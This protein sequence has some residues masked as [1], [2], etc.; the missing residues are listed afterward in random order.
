MYNG[1]V[2]Q[3]NNAKSL[4]VNITTWRLIEASLKMKWGGV[5]RVQCSDTVVAM[6]TDLAQWCHWPRL[7]SK[8]TSIHDNVLCTCLSAVSSHCSTM[9]WPS[10]RRLRHPPRP[11]IWSCVLVDFCRSF[12][13]GGSAGGRGREMKSLCHNVNSCAYFSSG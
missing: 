10:S 6:V 5:D 13:E 7:Y 11:L 1:C 8:C 3:R 2:H 9:S 12:L 4:S